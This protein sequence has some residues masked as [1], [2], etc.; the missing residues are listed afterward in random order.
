MIHC[1]V[2]PM[3]CVAWTEAWIFLGLLEIKSTEDAKNR[4]TWPLDSQ[5]QVQLVTWMPKIDTY[6]HLYAKHRYTWSL[7]CQKQVR[8]VSTA[9]QQ[10]Q[11]DFKITTT[12]C[13]AASMT[14][15]AVLLPRFSYLLDARIFLGL[16]GFKRRGA[17]KTGT[18]WDAIGRKK[19]QRDTF[20]LRTKNTYVA[21]A[22][23]TR[24]PN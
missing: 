11:V 15:V 6:G 7:G 19:K 2:M 1:T 16:F 8:F 23:A 18:P 22:A 9:E 4:Y 20:W 21:A 14:C 13:N 3:I 24:T 12:H 10:Q 17:T 5:K